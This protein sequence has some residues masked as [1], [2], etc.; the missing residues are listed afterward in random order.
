MFL[1]LNTSDVSEEALEASNQLM[2][3]HLSEKQRQAMRLL[4]EAMKSVFYMNVTDF[5]DLS[6]SI[7]RLLNKNWQNQ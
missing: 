3:M 5:E 2:A 4:S 1:M 7:K 6:S